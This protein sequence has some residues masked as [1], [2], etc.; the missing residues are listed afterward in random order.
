MQFIETIRIENK[1]IELIDFHL[2]RVYITA[3]AHNFYAPLLAESALIAANPYPDDIVKCRLVYDKT[4]IVSVSYEKYAL[5]TIS[6]LK[7]VYDDAITYDFKSTDR[8]A[9][10]RL[11]E[12]KGDADEIIIVKNGMVTDTSYSNIVFSKD[13]VLYTPSTFLLNGTRRHSLLENNTIKEIDIKVED[14]NNFD[15]L[16]IINAMIKPGE[17]VVNI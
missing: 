6:K 16:M 3:L 9:I 10:N 15:S 8:D 1:Q 7:T 14:I 11:Y 17:L 5:R 13:G 4:G 2:E 12:M